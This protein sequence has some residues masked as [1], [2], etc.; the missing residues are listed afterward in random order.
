MARSPKTTKT[1][2]KKTKRQTYT[3]TLELMTPVQCTF[4]IA[5]NSPE[6]AIEEA[7][8]LDWDDYEYV[9][10]DGDENT[11]CV[12]ITDESGA[13]IEV[14]KSYQAPITIEESR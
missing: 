8:D 1:S 9:G 3:V 14:P 2:K 10:P 13:N 11:Y 6:A 4:E 7:M 5:A 12:E